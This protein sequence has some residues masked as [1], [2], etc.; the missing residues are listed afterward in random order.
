MASAAPA[1]TTLAPTRRPRSTPAT[2]PP[3][4]KARTLALPMFR[5]ER[6]SKLNTRP[7]IFGTVPK[8]NTAPLAASDA[9]SEAFVS[10]TTPL[11]RSA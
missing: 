6:L 10:C 2:S 1:A 7:L 11:L 8:L 4:A 9:E 5:K 3:R